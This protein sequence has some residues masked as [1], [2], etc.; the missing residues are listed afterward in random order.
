[1]TSLP[2]MPP[3]ARLVVA[4]LLALPLG[5]APAYRGAVLSGPIDLSDPQ[6][7]EGRRLFDR[8]CHQ[9]HPNASAGLGP[10]ITPSSTIVR[11]Q[12]R[13]GLGVMP[14]FGPERITDEELDALVAYLM[15][16]RA[17][18]IEFRSP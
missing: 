4:L 15:L 10:S 1:M 6:V 11:F 17:F 5:C 7:A 9:C 3:V 14:A 8:H 18:G 13:H 16:V 2:P 12:V